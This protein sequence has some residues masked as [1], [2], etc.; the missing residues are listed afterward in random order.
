MGVKFYTG[1]M[2]PKEYK[3][4]MFIARKGSWN[5]TEKFG[6]DVVNVRLSAD[7]KSAKLTPFLTGFMDPKENTFWGRPAYIAQLQ[8]GS[9]LVSDEQLGVIYR[10]SQRAPEIVLL[11]PRAVGVARRPFHSAAH[12]QTEPAGRALHTC[13][14]CHGADGSWTIAGTPSI[15]AP[16]IF[17]ENYLVMTRG[18]SAARRDAGLLR[19]VGQ[20]DRRARKSYSA[21]AK[22]ATRPSLRSFSKGG[23]CIGSRCSGC[24]DSTFRGRNR[25][26]L[27]GQREEFHASTAVQN[28]RRAA[29]HHDRIAGHCRADF[30]ALAHYFSRLK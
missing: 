8:D 20:G 5:R 1:D 24:H 9:L 12:G 23:N 4:T 21:E 14:G 28:R 27:A 26:R 29:H 16:R 18:A 15:A 11:L 30:K 10:I 3:G 19:R 6:Y 22:T 25:Y 7:G 2:F 17:V 13:A